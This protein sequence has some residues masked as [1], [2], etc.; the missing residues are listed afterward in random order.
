MKSEGCAKKI[1]KL[2]DNIKKIYEIHMNLSFEAS[3][4]FLRI[5][6]LVELF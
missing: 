2:C 3:A 1:H 6:V 5:I 4:I